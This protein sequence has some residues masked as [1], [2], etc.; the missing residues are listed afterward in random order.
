VTFSD[1]ITAVK[2]WL[3]LA[4]GIYRQGLDAE[5]QAEESWKSRLI[6]EDHLAACCSFSSASLFS[7]AQGYER[8]TCGSAGRAVI[9]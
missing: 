3:W 2:R 5:F 4:W 9:R 8:K 7:S 6:L 1:A